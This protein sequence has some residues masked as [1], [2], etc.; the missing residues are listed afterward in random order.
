MAIGLRGHDHVALLLDLREV[1]PAQLQT[2]ASAVRNW[3]Q[4]RPLCLLPDADRATLQQWQAV[5]RHCQV[6]SSP[7]CGQTLLH[8]LQQGEPAGSQALQQPVDL[9]I[10]NSPAMLATRATVRKF[11]PVDLPVLVTG[12]TGTGKELAARALHALSAR[13]GAPFVAINCGAIPVSLMQAELFGHERGAFTGANAR[14]AGLFEHAHT[15][16]VFLDE[17]GELPAD[18]QTALLRVL[19]EG[20][21]QRIGSHAP[22]QV[23]V[24]VIAA[25]HVDL[26][27]AVRDGRFRG[28]LYYRLNVLRLGMP[29][30]R[31]RGEDIVLLAEHALQCFRRRH[32][33]RARGFNAQ[34]RAAMLQ[35]DWPGNVRELLNRVQRAAVVSEHELI[36]PHDLDLADQPAAMADDADPLGQARRHAERQALLSCLQ[37]NDYNITATARAMHISRVTVYR[38][39]ARHDI[40][41]GALR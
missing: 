32:S 7:L 35:F 18:A 15:G 40:V 37:A 31:E 39:C 13:A 3:T 25:T 8:C 10:G 38:M 29:A 5:S 12:Q 14:R 4:P 2:L 22:V 21:L 33:V 9:L 23:D 27:Q 11:A 34:A 30:L 16:T 20:T 6:L 17:V 1:D 36:T 26:E 24:R 28:D 19:Q 41:P